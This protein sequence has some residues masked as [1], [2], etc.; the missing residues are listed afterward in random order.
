MRVSVDRTS[1]DLRSIGISAALAVVAG[2]LV[3]AVLLVCLRRAMGALSQPLSVAA[4]A[5]TLLATLGG[6]SLVRFLWCSLWPA[7]PLLRFLPSLC[8]VL[9]AAALWV[10]GTGVTS[11]VLLCLAVGLDLCIAAGLVR[12][13]VAGKWRS[14]K[15]REPTEGLPP[16]VSQQLTR[17]VTDGSEVIDGAL[18]ATIAA[19]LRMDH[20]HVAFCPPLD[21]APRVECEQIDGPPARIK[22]AQ[23]L[24]QGVRLELRL[25]SAAQEAVEIVVQFV[26]SCEAASH[27]PRTQA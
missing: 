6:A 7:H 8:V 16:E 23:S 2:C 25:E 17:R 15:L 22:V 3:A 14:S 5:M 10:P 12:Q 18:R 13:P 9:L 1:S 26:A 11:G 24:P 21:A 4:L 20:Y 19:G 27:Q